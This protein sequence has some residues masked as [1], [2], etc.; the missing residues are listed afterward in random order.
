MPFETVR[1]RVRWLAAA[2]LCEIAEDGVRVPERAMEAQHH[3]RRL[4]ANYELVKN[5]YARLRAAGRCA[6]HTSIWRIG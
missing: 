2:G 4:L 5:L 6:G 1:R 3:D